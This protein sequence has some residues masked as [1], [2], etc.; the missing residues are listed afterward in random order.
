MVTD[1]LSVKWYGPYSFVDSGVENVFTCSMGE[2]KG[3]YLFTI[4]FEGKY[5]VYYV[6]ET[7]A[8]FANRMLQHAQ[9][10]LNGFY[11]I[12]DPE[13]FVKGR[14]IL[15]WGGMWKADRREPKLISDFIDKQAE[16][17]PKIIL[18]LKQFR[19]FL[20]PIGKDKRI[21]ERVEAEIARSLNQQEGLI[22]AFQ[23][24]DV[25]YRPTSPDEQQFW[26]MMTFPQPIMG[27]TEKLFV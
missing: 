27:L 22:G 13:E 19:I 20:A 8:S 16:L 1:P 9:S 2:K 15:L 11:R 10:Y 6:G 7:G 26:V 17:A 25:R 23:D 3:V 14:K 4:P 18:F 5:L 12:F 24:K 21:I